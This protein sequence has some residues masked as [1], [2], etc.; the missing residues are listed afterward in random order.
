LDPYAQAP[1]PVPL[2]R[3]DYRYPVAY[4]HAIVEQALAGLGRHRGA[5]VVASTGLGKTVIATDIARRLRRDGLVEEVLL[6]A[7]NAVHREWSDHLASARMPF[8][9]HNVQALD[10]AAGG[11]RAASE[12]QDRLARL[13]PRRL[14]MIDECH[15]LRNR[16]SGGRERRAFQRLLPAVARARCHVLLLT[17]T[18]FST[19]LANLNHQLLLLPHTAPS[20]ALIDERDEFPRAWRVRRAE[21]L[22]GLPV[23]VIATTPR[24]AHRYG[25]RDERGVFLHFGRTRK[26]F[27]TV[28][29]H[30]VD[31]AVAL[32]REV[33]DALADG[34]FDPDLD[35][36][37]AGGVE[38]HVRLGLT[39][40]PWALREILTRTVAT[41]GPAGFRR[42]FFRME[43]QERQARLM[44]LL[45]RLRDLSFAQDPKLARLLD[46]LDTAAGTQDK[47]LVF[48]ER[49]ATVAYLRRA[50]RA[51]RP[52]L[53]V[54]A[55]VE[56]AAE[57]YRQKDLRRI[58]R[59]VDDFAPVAN[60]ARVARRG[61]YDVLLTTDAWGLGVNLQDARVVVSY[62][63]AWTPIELAQRA[64]RVLRLWNEPRV[65][66]IHGF[67]PDLGPQ[68]TDLAWRR[69]WSVVRRWETLLARHDTARQLLDLPSLTR[70]TRNVVAMDAL[71]PASLAAAGIT[72]LGELDLAQLDVMAGL[73]AAAD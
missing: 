11:S 30:R 37:A 70:D 28:A 68:V 50:L 20:R 23:A 16:H 19:R 46:L 44:P 73:G 17:A 34:V 59:I 47:C 38:R 22:E 33:A 27:P 45:D 52:D 15:L 66:D 13:G 10:A 18:P 71:A 2:P 61:G 6:V 25:Q 35:R 42:V 51:L 24:V 9:L 41:P 14:L 53:R 3:P 40:S 67:V 5:F 36:G 43:Q 49:L 4:Q 69:L 64:G 7:P 12:L 54:G 8:A 32:G 26:Y 72:R 55:T 60:N 57:G 65:V 63:L 39:S 29:L 62:D 56:A 58:R 31:T 21:E 1:F 48:C